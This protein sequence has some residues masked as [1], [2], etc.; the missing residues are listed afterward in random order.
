MVQQK[1][2]QLFR[3]IVEEESGIVVSKLMERFDEQIIPYE[4]EEDPARPSLCRDEFEIFLKETIEENTKFRGNTVEIGVGDEKKLGFGDELYEDTTDCIKILGTI[5]QGIAGD[6]VFV[7]ESG[8]GRFGGGFLLPVGQ[9]RL[10][11]LDKGWD[12]EAPIWSFSRFPGIPDF[13][14]G[15][16]LSDFAKKVAERLGNA[17]KR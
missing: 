3:R 14:S 1:L 5:I 13:F 12:V 8:E 10:E 4:D 9:Y 11:A 6:Y 17:L 15:L 7:E 16:D 2:L